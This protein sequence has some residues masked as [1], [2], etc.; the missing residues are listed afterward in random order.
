V[1]CSNLDRNTCLSR[2]RFVVVF[3]VSSTASQITP[4]SLPS[5]T[6][7]IHRSSLILPLDAVQPRSAAQTGGAGRPFP[8][9]RKKQRQLLQGREQQWHGRADR[10]GNCLHGH[11]VPLCLQQLSGC[12]G[13]SGDSHYEV[14][15][16]CLQPQSAYQTSHSALGTFLP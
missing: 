8:N 3:L 5:K 6:L 4:Q 12:V 15:T 13:V 7:P 11:S 9:F 16:F 14:I 2:M 10:A 1:L